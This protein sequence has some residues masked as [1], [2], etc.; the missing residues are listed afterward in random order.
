MLILYYIFTCVRIWENVF[1][2]P[3]A[4]AD[5]DA[6]NVYTAEHKRYYKAS[7]MCTTSVTR[8]Q[9]LGKVRNISGTCTTSLKREQHLCH[10]NNISA[11]CTTSLKRAQH[12]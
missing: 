2:R 4:F 6:L 9:M 11:T 12:L 7:E 1:G 5:S 3:N 10:V 8:A